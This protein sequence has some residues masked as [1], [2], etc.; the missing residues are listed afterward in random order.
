MDSIGA[1]TFTIP[2]GLGG[3]TTTTDPNIAQAAGV[4]AGG[5]GLGGTPSTGCAWYNPFCSSA[6]GTSVSDTIAQYFVRSVVII[7]GF[8][9][10]AAGL[11]MFKGNTVSVS[12]LKDLK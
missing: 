7:L 6:G 1:Q 10:I 5:D 12:L 2:D 8:I 9:F 3:T 11:Y 4:Q